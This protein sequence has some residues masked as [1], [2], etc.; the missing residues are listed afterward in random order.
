[1]T[2]QQ[3]ASQKILVIEDDLYISALVSTTLARERFTPI[4]AHD[5]GIGLSEA[6]RLLPSLI[7]LDIMLPTMDGWEVCRRLRAEEK[8]R[9]I[10]IIMV[11]AKSEEED[12]VAGLDIGADDYMTKPFSVRELVARIR[13]LLRR[14]AGRATNTA[15][16]LRVGALAIDSDRHIITIDGTPVHL[17]MMEFAILQRLAQEPGRVFTRD[18]LLTFLWGAD[19][20]VQ[21]HNLDVHIHTIRRKIEADPGHPLYV[22]TVRGIGYRLRD[23]NRELGE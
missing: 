23:P 22:Q 3:P 10:P 15:K 19:C 21:E 8:T 1:M 17:T 7:L 4:V 16:L 13:A 18:Q 9:A 5:G 2:H 6:R 20:Y 12:R 14:K 11:T